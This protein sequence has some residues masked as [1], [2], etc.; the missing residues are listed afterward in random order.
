MKIIVINTNY[1][2]REN[3]WQLYDPVD[4]GNQL[5]WLVNEL[6]QAEKNGQIVHIVGHAPITSDACTQT[7]AHNYLMI[8]DRFRSII[9]T[10]FF[11]HTHRDELR[12]YYPS[13]YSS[14]MY[15]SQGE[16]IQEKVEKEEKRNERK[17]N[18]ENV[19][20][21]SSDINFHTN[22]FT[23]SNKEEE[24]EEEKDVE[25]EMKSEGEVDPI[26]VGFVGGSITTFGYVNPCYK[27][28]Q[29]NDEVS[30]FSLSLL[31]SF[32]LSLSLF[33]LLSLP[34]FY[35][36]FLSEFLTFHHEMA[37]DE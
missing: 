27:V 13:R 2:S 35:L 8:I 15:Q 31:S 23:S 17:E 19:P 34:F 6:F 33:F 12:L 4:P 10:S 29:M 5:Q 11:G 28:Y 22:E 1:C 36:F 37:N 32:P 18:E 3:F 14:Q 7:W 9:K 21:S 25:K 30:D 26:L 24:K 16:Q 20:S